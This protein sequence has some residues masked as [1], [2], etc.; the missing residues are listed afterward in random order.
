M[1]GSGFSGVIES[2]RDLVVG[3]KFLSFAI[4]IITARY[5]WRR[6]SEVLGVL[7][8]ARMKRISRRLRGLR[9][10]RRGG[11]SNEG[12]EDCDRQEEVDL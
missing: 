12:C 6:K 10:A 3:Y 5:L 7:M 4:A 1:D 11:S 8:L 9:W 2:G